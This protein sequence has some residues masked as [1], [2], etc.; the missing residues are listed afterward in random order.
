MTDLEAHVNA[1]GRDKLVKQ[2]REK[3]NELGVT[4]I[5]YQFI[6]VTGRIVGKGIP[7]DHWERTAERGFQLVYGSTA[8]LY[9][10]RHGDY[11]GYGPE[12]SE[13]VGIPD[14]E[15]FSQLPWDK[16]VARVFCTCFRNREERENPGGHLTSDCRGNLRIIHNEFQDKYDGLHLRCGTEPEMMWLKRGEDGRPN[17]GVTK[18]N[19]YHID[20]FE[21]LRPTF[22]KVI[23]YSQA[24]G[25]DIIQGDHED[26][27][28]QLELNTMFD[29]VLRN[30]DRL[31]TYRQICAQVAREDGLIACFMSKPFMG[32]SASGCHHNM[33]LWRGGK[34][35][36]NDLHNATL[37]GMEGAFTYLTGGENTFMPDL[38]LDERKPGPIGLQ[39]IG[40]VMKHLGALTS[41]GSSTVNSYRRL[42]DTGFWAPVFADWGYQ[43]R[44]CALR[45]SAPGRFEYRSVDSMVNPYLMGSALLKAFDDGISNNLDPGEP[46]ERNI[47][48]AIEAGKQVMKLPM[49]L[50]EAL[51]KLADDEVIKSSM[52]D[53]M[54]RVFHHYKNDEWERFNHTVTEWDLET[55]ID[56]LP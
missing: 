23:E 8:N 27:P 17:G 9:V 20:Q 19:C 21:E 1:E 3:I 37:P 41:I 5:Y 35:T 30:A 2:V 56:C 15:T 29:D 34:D 14:P 16:R 46:E 18:P 49:S 42:W 6:S 39:C 32:V 26:A 22:M 24:M 33:S 43:N 12:S 36:V 45:I 11:I 10:D 4:Y 47:Y 13:L 48:E 54:Y 38:S 52:P 44:T 40:G 7:A 25:L 28:G 53:E 51:Q 50:G 55:Y 31:T